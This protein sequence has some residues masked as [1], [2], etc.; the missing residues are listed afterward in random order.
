MR[1]RALVLLTAISLAISTLAIAT[2]RTLAQTTNGPLVTFVIPGSEQ[3]AD[4]AAGLAV[5]RQTLREAGYTEAKTLRLEAR[6]LG[7]R[8]DRLPDVLADS[9]TR[10]TQVIVVVGTMGAMVAQRTTKTIPVVFIG[11]GDPVE[12]GIVSSLSRPGGNMTG[13][14][15]G[16]SP[17]DHGKM[18]QLL[19]EAVPGVKSVA[20]IYGKADAIELHRNPVSVAM[21]RAAA[22]LG[23]E[24]ERH[25]VD[26]EGDLHREL[27]LIKQKPP[28]ALVVSGATATYVHRKLIADFALRHGLPSI[29][30]FSEAVLDGALMSYG[31]SLREHIQRGAV[32]V[33]KILGGAKPATLPVEQPTRFDVVINLKTAKALGLTIPPSL[34][35]RANQVIE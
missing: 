31:P 8:L 19:R 26:S 15:W 14:A 12:A 3:D 22:S 18:L 28:Q 11:V 24:I 30:Q 25:P 33:A 6:F 29:H 1:R 32:Y 21:D 5:F 27:S 34:L 23:I 2:G 35:L 13:T 7:G 4:A 9:P 10:G 20:T 16:A 17:E